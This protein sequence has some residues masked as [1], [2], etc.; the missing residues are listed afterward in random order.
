MGKT[1][2]Q[3]KVAKKI[4]NKRHYDGRVARTAEQAAELA[5]LKKDLA[6]RDA[7]LALQ[8]EVEQNTQRQLSRLYVQSFVLRV[9]GCGLRTLAQAAIRPSLTAAMVSC[10][11]PTPIKRWM[12]T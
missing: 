12:R 7:Q 8:Y 2:E 3:G 11:P 6:A 4:T 10:S 1:A 9:R 5:D